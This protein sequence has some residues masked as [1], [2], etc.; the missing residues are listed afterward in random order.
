MYLC[1]YVSM[2]PCIF[3]SL[4][5]CIYVSMYLCIYVC[6]YVWMDGRN[7]PARS[8]WSFKQNQVEV[9]ETYT[10]HCLRGPARLSG[11][12]GGWKLKSV[13]HTRGSWNRNFKI[14]NPAFYLPNDIVR[15]GTEQPFVT[16]HWHGGDWIQKMDGCTYVYMDGWMYGCMDVC[17]YACMDVCTYVRMYVCMCMCI[18]VCVCMCICIC[19]CL[20]KYIYIYT[21]KCID[22]WGMAIPTII[23]GYKWMFH[24]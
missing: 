11:G 15:T 18:C 7:W 19:M 1:I 10:S 24:N 14:T 6:M 4:Y 22:V 12:L 21:C 3:V 16:D 17:V 20:H 9:G 23:H 2:Y 13:G 8:P 5:L